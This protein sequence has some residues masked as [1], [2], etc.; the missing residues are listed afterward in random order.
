MQGF[1]MEMGLSASGEKGYVAAQAIDL[2]GTIA[3][4]AATA[5]T[6]PR[7]RYT[8]QVA[9]ERHIDS[10]AV[11]YLNH[12]CVPN[13]FVDAGTGDV[14]ALRPLVAGEPLGFFYPSTEWEMSSP[15]DCS[16]GHA[17]CLGRIDG[18]H[19][20]PDGVLRRYALNDHIRE[21]L[22]ERDEGKRAGSSLAPRG[23]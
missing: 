16:C 7:D 9:R 10:D 3:S 15:F 2:G 4:W 12:S 5:V 13:T 1:L 19:G 18:A 22:A 21:L 8:V 20:L 14:V 23:R 11:R 17:G 6:S